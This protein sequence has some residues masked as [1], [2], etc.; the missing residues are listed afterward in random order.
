[1]AYHFP[2]TLYLLPCLLITGL[3]FFASCKEQKPPKEVISEGIIHYKISYPPEINRMSISFLLPDKMDFYFQ[4]NKVRASFRGSL[5]LYALDFI[6]N[7]V[8]DS[9]ITLLKILDKKMYVPGSESDRL[10]IFNNLK[11]AN[12]TLRKDTTRKIAG[13]TAH[14]ATVS[15]ASK[16]HSS[17][18]VWY[19]PEMKTKTTNKNTP[20]SKIPGVML[21]FDLHYN[22]ILFK[23]KTESVEPNPLPPSTFMVPSNYKATSMEE[24]EAIIS[25]LLK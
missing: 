23:L 2:R 14:M 15:T 17:V 22:N 21:E 20:F 11:S 10:F 19:T 8:S 13:F 7:H 25:G 9:S 6:S 12:V 1:M 18:V 5:G 3:L 4:P 24:I 16:A